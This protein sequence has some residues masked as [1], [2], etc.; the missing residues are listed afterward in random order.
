[1]DAAKKQRQQAEQQAEEAQKKAAKREKALAII[2]ATVQGALA[3]VRAIAAPP[4]F[5]LNLPTVITTG[6]LA[7]AQVATIA[8]QPLATGGVIT[9]RRVTDRQNIPTQRNGDNVLATVKR[10][11]VVLN[12]RHQRMLGGAATFKSIGV[13]GFADSG[14]IGSPNVA[15]LSSA[16]NERIVELIEAVNG[17]IDRLQ[18]Y[19]VSDDVAKD[20]QERDKL[21]V[22]ATL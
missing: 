20:L 4:G 12:E 1:M 7:A 17:R 5:P 2:Q 11:E 15:A 16:S 9:G 18:A 19:V 3:V 6:V 14:A 22:D 13:P 21:R 10:G 8:A